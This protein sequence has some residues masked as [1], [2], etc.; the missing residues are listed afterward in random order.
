MRLMQWIKKGMTR[1]ARNEGPK[2][3]ANEWDAERQAREAERRTAAARFQQ[4]KQ[5]AARV[6]AT[7]ER[8]IAIRA[9]GGQ[10]GNQ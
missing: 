5:R 1:H 7:V 2:P 8:D 4:L 3:T 10:V 6:S 9:A